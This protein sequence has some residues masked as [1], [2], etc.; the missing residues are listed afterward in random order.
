MPAAH[1]AAAETLTQRR[2][3]GAAREI[4]LAIAA[5]PASIDDRL[6]GAAIAAAQGH[7]DEAARTLARLVVEAPEQ[8]GIRFVIAYVALQRGDA[9]GALRGADD[10]LALRPRF[11]Q[12]RL[13]R[14]AALLGLSRPRRGSRRAAAVP[15][16]SA[17]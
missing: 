6:A 5:D 1:R 13:L 15:E 17:A 14:G 9:S 11:A 16:R 2:L 10:A 8:A 12:A 7:L 3:D 4:G